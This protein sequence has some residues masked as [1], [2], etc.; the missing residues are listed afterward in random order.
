MKKIFLIITCFIGLS[1]ISLGQ[2]CGSKAH[3]SDTAFTIHF[4]RDELLHDIE[5]LIHNYTKKSSKSNM[6]A[7]ASHIDNG[8]LF[9]IP[10]KVWVY[11][12]EA[13]QT[14]SPAMTDIQI[15]NRIADLNLIYAPAGIRFY[16]KCNIEHLSYCS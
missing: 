12:R 9:N 11:N 14:P 16:L 13:P 10:M 15:E 7:T 1:E 6:R 4:G 5:K 3:I 8:I 2:M